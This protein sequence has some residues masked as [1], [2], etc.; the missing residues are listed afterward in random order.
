MKGI[1]AADLHIRAD[2]PRCRIDENWEVTQREMVEELVSIAN[3]YKCELFLDGDIFDSPNC[4]ARF[5]VMMIEE[6]SKI[7]TKVYF[8]AGNHEIPY[9]SM[10]NVENSSI[11]IFMSMAKEHTKIVNG[12]SKYG[13]WSHFNSEIKGKETGLLFM[14][15]LVFENIKS[16]PPNTQAITAQ[17]LLSEYPN[18]KYIFLGDNHGSFFY[19]KNNRYVINPGCTIRQSVDEQ[20]YKPSVF[21]V[22]TDKEIIEKIFLSDDAKM[23]EDSYIIERDMKE[24][25]IS[26]FVEKLRN[27]ESVNLD[28]LENIENGLLTNKKLSKDTVKMIRYLCEEK[29]EK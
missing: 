1:I 19:K 25:R 7:D 15:R 22:D 21:F 28:F 3:K 5:I 10:D 12:M 14:H 4:P 6:L 11:G 8:I 24:N 20:S 13:Q 17:D 29:E 16:M 18:I 26:A 27:N 23:V 2:R 9:H